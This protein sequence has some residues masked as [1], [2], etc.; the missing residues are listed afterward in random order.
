MSIYFCLLLKVTAT[1]LWYILHLQPTAYSVTGYKIWTHTCNTYTLKGM[2]C[3]RKKSLC[4][5][6]VMLWNMQG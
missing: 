1:V 3:S 6:A 5:N 2:S 4:C